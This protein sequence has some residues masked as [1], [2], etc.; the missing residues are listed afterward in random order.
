MA[1]VKAISERRSSPLPIVLHLVTF[2]HHCML[3]Y[4]FITL[5]LDQFDHPVV[6]SIKPFKF[7]TISGWSFQL[8]MHHVVLSLYVDWQHRRGCKD[9]EK[10]AK[11]E[12]YKDMLFRALVLPCTLL[13]SVLFW[14]LYLTDRDLVYP[15]VWDSI[16]PPW[17]NHGVHTSTI[18]FTGLEL[19]V[20]RSGDGSRRIEGIMYWVLSLGYAALLNLLYLT[21]G[22]W[23]YPFL[24]MLS[25]Y[26]LV[27]FLIFSCS[28][29]V[30]LEAAWRIDGVGRLKTLKCN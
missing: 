10:L 26:R 11:C 27:F 2:L 5:D 19:L 25:W 1:D 22:I 13:V 15:A 24:G 9:R 12:L 30:L 4:G 17:M 20:A 18:L 21:C 28:G 8:Q 29:R 16:I 23:F 7:L 3:V 6:N 14:V